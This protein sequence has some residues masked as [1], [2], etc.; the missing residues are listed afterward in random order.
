MEVRGAEAR[1]EVKRRLAPILQMKI[2]YKPDEPEEPIVP[3]E[4]KKKATEPK[5]PALPPQDL[6]VLAEPGII[7]CQRKTHIMK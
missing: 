6:L 1:R 4:G 3:G 2:E 5:K 7:F